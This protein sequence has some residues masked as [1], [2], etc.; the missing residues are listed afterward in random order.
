MKNL[1]TFLLLIPCLS[2]AQSDSIRHIVVYGESNIEI[3]PDRIELTIIF[4]E[5]EN[6]RKENELQLKEN[7]LKSLIKTHNIGLDKLSVDYLAATSQ[8]NYYKTSSNKFMVSKTF[9]LQLDKIELVDTLIRELFEIGANSVTVSNLD[10]DKLE[11]VKLDAI[12]NALERANKKAEAMVANMGLGLGQIVQMTELIPSVD[13]N[14]YN[15]INVNKGIRAYGVNDAISIDN[16]IG[17]RKIT[18]RFQVKVKY[19]IK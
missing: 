3:E 11:D 19:E 17:V 18:V 4:T 9:K 12:K 1:F 16:S 5:T 10:S 2:L 8:I 6:L 13:N 14:V 7:E 15:G